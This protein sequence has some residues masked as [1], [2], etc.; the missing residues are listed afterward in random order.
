MLR[1]Y[2]NQILISQNVIQFQESARLT[3]MDSCFEYSNNHTFEA[4]D[5]QFT[6]TLRS[7]K[8]DANRGLQEICKDLCAYSGKNSTILRFYTVRINTQQSTPLYSFFLDAFKAYLI[9]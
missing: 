9:V 2:F 4:L 8:T 3:T 5:P 1:D 7:D 6:A